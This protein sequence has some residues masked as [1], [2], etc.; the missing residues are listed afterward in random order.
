MEMLQDLLPAAK[1]RLVDAR[2]VLTHGSPTGSVYLAGYSVEMVLKHAALRVDRV[3]LTAP[4][5]AAAAVTRARLKAEVG[6]VEPEH[7][8]SLRFW[9]LILRAAW[10]SRRGVVPEIVNEAVSKAERLYQGWMVDMRYRSM[11]IAPKDA[12]EFFRH[13]SWFVSHA[14]ELAR[15]R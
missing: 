15:E 9:A 11:M 7:Y 2:A 8:H 6:E 5:K 13:A 1:E 4:P 10:R 12:M 14:A 3:S